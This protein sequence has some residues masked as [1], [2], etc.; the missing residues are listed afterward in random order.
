M[1]ERHE[2]GR[3]CFD[4]MVEVYCVVWSADQHVVPE[5]SAACAVVLDV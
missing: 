4:G 5:T 1:V 2:L 3:L